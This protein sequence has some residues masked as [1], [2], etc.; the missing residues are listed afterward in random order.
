MT[1]S[2]IFTIYNRVRRT[3][4]FC[5]QRTNRAL[6]LLQSKGNGYHEKYQSTS[7]E[8]NC[9]DHFYR[10]VICKHMIAELMIKQAR[11]NGKVLAS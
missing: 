1:K 5:P 11:Q 4:S 9:P 8:C 3:D 10:E 2:E 7:S 6:G